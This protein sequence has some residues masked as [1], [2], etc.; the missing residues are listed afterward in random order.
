MGNFKSIDH[1]LDSQ[2]S[3]TTSDLDERTGAKT[4]KA[5][6]N[7]V[8]SSSAIHRSPMRG[9]FTE[10]EHWFFKYVVDQNGPD[11]II[12]DLVC[13]NTSEHIRLNPW[14]QLALQLDDGIMVRVFECSAK[15]SAP[16]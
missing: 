11:N 15:G 7:D 16:W 4:S 12:A 13:Q 14:Y 5:L 3:K 8:C 1:F 10:K 2:L 9:V 6:F